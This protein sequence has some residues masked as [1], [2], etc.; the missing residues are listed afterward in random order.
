MTL[1]NPHHGGIESQ[2]R[3][4]KRD[5]DP[6]VVPNCVDWLEL[7]HL[8]EGGPLGEEIV[9]HAAGSLQSALWCNMREFLLVQ[10]C[11]S[12]YESNK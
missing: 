7:E 4:V 11:K 10:E 2:P 8:L 1:A 5:F 12:T 6:V 3:K 9:P